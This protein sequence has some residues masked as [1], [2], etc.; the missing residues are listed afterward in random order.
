MP[1]SLSGQT[2]LNQYHVE[3]FIALTPLGELYRATDTRNNK[4]L[5]LTLLPKTISESAEV[6]KKLEADSVKLRGISHPNIVPYLGLYQ[7]P[8]LAFLLEEWI[9]GPSLHDMLGKE[10][11]TV[12]EALIY[13]KAI[14]SA[15]ETLHKQNY[16]HLNLAPEL[17]RINKRGEIFL[18]GIGTARQIGA[19]RTQAQSKYP[20]LYFSPEQFNEQPLTPASDTY[21][22]AALLYQLTPGAWINGKPAPKSSVHKQQG[23]P[24]SM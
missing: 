6:L 19:K 20:H 16:L 10:P 18:G 21:A 3:E 7:T 8:S 9:D 23:C 5:A 24:S 12:D 2:L 17:I 15:L 11:L 4:S 13:V 1:S 14:C 22:L